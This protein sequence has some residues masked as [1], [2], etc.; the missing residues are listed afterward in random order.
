MAKAFVHINKIKN[1][2]ALKSR[3]NHDLNTEFRKQH[4]ANAD[5][6]RNKDNDILVACT[7]EDGNEISYEKAVKN[8]IKG[9]KQPHGR[10]IRKDAV[11]AY[12]IVLEFGDADDIE[13]ENIDVEEWE[14]RSVEW[15]KETFNVAG[16]GKDNVISVVCH[17]DESSP[18]IHAVVTPVNEDGNL[19]AKPAFFF[20]SFFCFKP[21]FSY[22]F[23]L[24]II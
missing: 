19:C 12:D 3:W 8:R 15:L 16:D 22:S 14:R 7:D 17:K 5:P 24:S 11:I 6:D 23:S 21:A 4:V 2:G 10:N 20:C 13:S 18:H 9:K 1:Y